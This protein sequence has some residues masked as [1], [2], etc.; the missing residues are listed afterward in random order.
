MCNSSVSVVKHDCMLKVEMIANKVLSKYGS[1]RP[2]STPAEIHLSTKQEVADSHQ[3]LKQE[4][5]KA[6]SEFTPVEMLSLTKQEG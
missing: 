3:S 5:G 1:A 4:Y 2:E 6:V